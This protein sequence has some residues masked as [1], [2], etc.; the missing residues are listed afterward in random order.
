MFANFL[1]KKSVGS[2]VCF[3]CAMGLLLP[4]TA[5]AGFDWTP[6]PVPAAAPSVAPAPQVDGPLTPEPDAPPVPVGAV[7]SAPVQRHPVPLEVNNS[8][9]APAPMVAPTAEKVAEKATPAPA[10][11]EPLPT[12]EPTPTATATPEPAPAPAPTPVAAAK[13]VVAPTSAYV[14]EPVVEGFGKD[15]PLVIAL[16]DIVP[17]KYAYA[18][19]PKDIAG[20]KISWRGGKPWQDV[21]KAA[22]DT[23][24]FGM[25]VTDTQVLIYAKQYK[26]DAA[27]TSPTSKAPS[28]PPQPPAAPVAEAKP[29]P[30]SAPVSYP[31]ESAATTSEA[32]SDPLPLTETQSADT[33]PSQPQTAE[34]QE[35]AMKAATPVTPAPTVESDK[36]LVTSAMDLNATRKWQARPG[37]TLR[38]TLEAWAKDTNVELNWSTPYDYPINNAF[39]FDG[40]FTQ[41]VDSL[42]SSYGGEN[43]SPKG[44][45]YPNLPEG[46]SVLMIN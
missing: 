46:P 18:F 14:G 39:Y 27:P 6:P 2:A 33:K 3:L 19:S 45:L 28:A 31:A 43:P 25:Q 16:R 23:V 37:T 38:Q 40:K 17:A 15:I 44:R 7:E 1:P 42:L 20:T 30:E 12:P 26:S 10:A 34:E 13:P 22:L 9:D 41:A 4:S 32:T 36:P 11:A 29:E 5:Q 21:L 24:D 35:A 8:K